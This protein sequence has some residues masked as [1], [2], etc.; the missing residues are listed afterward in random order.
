MIT[1][2]R[3]ANRKLYD[4]NIKSYISF[5]D[6]ANYVKAGIDFKVLD[7]KD[8]CRD[9]TSATLRKVALPF[10][11]PMTDDHLKSIIKGS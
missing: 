5:T 2:K 9:I 1:I 6:L 4:D 8:N 11:P 10:I 7:V 3:Y